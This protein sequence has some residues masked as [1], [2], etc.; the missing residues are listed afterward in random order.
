MA[1]NW[2]LFQRQRTWTQGWGGA[3][4]LTLAAPPGHAHFLPGVLGSWQ[5]RG[6]PGTSLSRAVLEPR[7]AAATHRS[8]QF[9]VKF[10]QIWGIGWHQIS[11]LK[12]ATVGVFTKSVT[13]AVNQ[14]LFF[15][16][17][18]LLNVYQHT[19]AS[20]SAFLGAHL[21]EVQAWWDHQ[22]TFTA[23]EEKQ[24]PPSR[25]IPSIEMRGY[26]NTKAVS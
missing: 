1:T 17:S 26:V 16:E 21:G 22:S 13:S 3:F 11:S 19:T 9:S 14:N 4:R 6:W 23:K 20:V 12:S 5:L 15:P 10:L 8:Q 25:W 7:H 24:S 2:P 18:Q